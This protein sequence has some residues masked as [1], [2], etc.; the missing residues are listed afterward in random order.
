MI[1]K[2]IS[3]WLK[4]LEKKIPKAHILDQY[5]N[6][7]N[8]MAHYEGTAEEILTDLNNQVDMVGGWSRDRRH[9]NWIG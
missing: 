3:V 5:S 6:P 1:R 2:A 8:Y 4:K 9:F 7:A